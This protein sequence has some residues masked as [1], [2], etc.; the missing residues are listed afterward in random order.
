MENHR[1]YSDASD[2]SGP[3]IHS[4]RLAGPEN[5]VLKMFRGGGKKAPNVVRTLNHAQK[6]NS[7]SN[8]K[9]S[10]WEKTLIEE[11]REE[12]IYNLQ[13]EFSYRLKQQTF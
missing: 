6:I 11:N 1:C 7:S 2:L 8:M 13:V 4:F 9:G 3:T 5:S 12:Y 10:K